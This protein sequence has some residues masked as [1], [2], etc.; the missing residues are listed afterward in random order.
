MSVSTAIHKARALPGRSNAQRRELRVFYAFISPWLAGFILVTLVP[1]LWGFYLSLTNFSGINFSSTTFTGLA[2]YVRA[3]RDPV[4]WSSLWNTVLVT[5]AYVPANLIG[6]F[7]LA[8]LL[9]RRI[10]GLRLF[11][12]MYY[13]PYVVPAVAMVVIWQTIYN[14]NSGLLNAALD[15]FHKGTVINWISDYPHLSLILMLLWGM[16]GGMIIYLAA[17]QGIPA[18][19][20]EAAAIDGASA[21]QSFRHVTV[22]LVTPVLFFQLIMGLI[23]AF[24]LLVPP[25]LLTSI[26]GGSTWAR[27]GFEI[28]QANRLYLVN[29]YEQTFKYQTFGYGLAL[30]WILVVI[31]FVFS[32]LVVKSG[33]FWVH[34]EVEVE[35]KRGRW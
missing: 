21:L 32:L 12:T 4:T 33:Q 26:A 3:L 7:L 5:A 30:A 22:P 25:M 13:L 24:Q 14:R 35:E 15:L 10:K 23:N 9:N 20:K 8:V 29:L 18:E 2:N 1:M 6:G 17:L 11:R 16:G 34:Y 27:E 31:V 28:P 19:L